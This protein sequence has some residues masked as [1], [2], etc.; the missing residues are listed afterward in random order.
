MEKNLVAYFGVLNPLTDCFHWQIKSFTHD[1]DYN[2]IVQSIY[3]VST[4]KETFI[5]AFG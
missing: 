4:Q 1:T 2:Y 5:V 3:L